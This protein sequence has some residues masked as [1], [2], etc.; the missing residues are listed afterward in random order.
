MSNES[1]AATV[2]LCPKC[3]GQKHVQK[4]PYI[5]GD[6]HSWVANNTGGFTCPVCNGTGWIYA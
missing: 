6:Q 3:G 4:P 5:A 2:V 1:S